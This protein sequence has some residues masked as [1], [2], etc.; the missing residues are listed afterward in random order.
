M[1]R[2]TVTLRRELSTL[3]VRRRLLRC[4]LRRDSVKRRQRT[5]ARPY[6]S[7]EKK[8]HADRKSLV[9]SYN[10]IIIIFLHSLA[11]RLGYLWGVPLCS[12]PLGKY[13]QDSPW[14]SYLRLLKLLS[15]SHTLY[16]R[17]PWFQNKTPRNL[18]QDP[19]S[20]DCKPWYR[21]RD[22]YCISP[23]LYRS[24]GERPTWTRSIFLSSQEQ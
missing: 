22:L 14:T 11:T 12:E 24:C 21:T 2:L 4:G 16:W 23:G 10:K 9:K 20:L 18:V 8:R 17:H 13:L 6:L 1:S 15:Q 7:S 19:A 3:S 5:W